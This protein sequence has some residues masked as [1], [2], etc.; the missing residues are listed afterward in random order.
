MEVKPYK[1]GEDSPCFL[2]L[3]FITFHL[4]L[5]NQV[6]FFLFEKSEK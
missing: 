6:A 5:Q 1:D 2:Y 4:R 3:A